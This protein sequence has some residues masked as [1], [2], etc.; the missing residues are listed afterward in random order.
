[1]KISV[2][3]V[4]RVRGPLEAA[5]QEFEMRAAHYWKLDVV[6]IES[7]VRRGD[8][9]DARSVRSS[10]GRRLLDR[11]PDGSDV[12]AL[13][14]GGP[15]TSSRAFA[16]T[17]GAKALEGSP[18]VTFLVGGAYGLDPEVLGRAD[19]NLSLSEMT[20]P[21]E[22]ARLVL[23]EQLYRAGTILRSEPYHKGDL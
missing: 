12:W 4:G 2:L 21:H 9:R 10:E 15:G 22:L 3:V 18:G 16:K 20:L 5:V 19:S 11:I 1:M 23:A 13:T 8:R 6:E 17:L 14:R 7:G